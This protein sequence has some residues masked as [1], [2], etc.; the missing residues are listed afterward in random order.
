M[1]RGGRGGG[2][3]WGGGGGGLGRDKQEVHG[4]H[5]AGQPAS[6]T[7]PPDTGPI[8]NHPPAAGQSVM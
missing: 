6:D 1:G 8:T 4:R 2:L 7:Q 5:H 3:V